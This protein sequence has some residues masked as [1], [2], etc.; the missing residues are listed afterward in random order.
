MKWD[1]FTT[2]IKNQDKQVFYNQTK[3][4]NCA[5][6]MQELEVGSILLVS[7]LVLL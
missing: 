5:C 6:H 3:T 2:E 1:T 4:K 7:F